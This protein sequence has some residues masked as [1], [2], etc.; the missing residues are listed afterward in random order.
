MRRSEGRSIKEI[1]RLVGVSASSVSLWVRDIEL[2]V[3]Q[4]AELQ[5]R[6]R[7]HNRQRLARAAMIAKARRKRVKAQAEGRR[8]ARSAGRLYVIGCMLYWAEGSRTRNKIVF[9]NSDPEM[10]RL[11][12]TFLKSAF[13]IEPSRVRLTC[14][15]FADHEERQREI[16]D[17]WLRTAGLSR[18][19]LCTSTVNHY[20]RYSQKKRK[21]KLPYG[22]CRI[23]VNSTEIAQTIC[24]SIQELA[25]FDRPEWLD[26]PP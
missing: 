21:N 3:E 15:L 19:S 20:S 4:H 8:R 25:G 24:G 6:N 11:F 5:V 1:A 10:V 12:G 23:V 26:L 16:E 17:F 2:T 9:T 22:T 7:L 13:E 14:N 18:A